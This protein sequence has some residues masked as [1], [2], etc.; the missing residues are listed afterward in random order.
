MQ[1]AEYCG[2]FTLLKNLLVYLFDNSINQLLIHATFSTTREDRPKPVQ[3]LGQCSVRCLHVFRQPLAMNR[4]QQ[5]Q[6]LFFAPP[7]G[8]ESERRRRVQ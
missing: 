6:P 8:R 2:Y 7:S 1:F 3:P 5:Q 4:S